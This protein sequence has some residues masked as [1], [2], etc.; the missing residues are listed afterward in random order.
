MW[1]DTPR[2]P[3]STPP[4]CS[5]PAAPRPPPAAER[6]AEPCWAWICARS[7]AWPTFP[8]PLPPGV[9]VAPGTAQRP[10]QR[11]LTT[12]TRPCPARESQSAVLLAWWAPRHCSQ[13]SAQQAHPP[14]ASKWLFS[15]TALCPHAQ[16]AAAPLL[17][18]C[19]HTSIG[20]PM[21]THMS[22]SQPDVPSPGLQQ[23]QKDML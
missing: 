18:R 8:S 16:S 3:R 9:K 23:G 1:E 7:C 4:G 15:C 22:C 19:P 17:P 5:T 14:S 21:G 2:S 11:Y 6:A 10:A 20:V 12:A 13:A